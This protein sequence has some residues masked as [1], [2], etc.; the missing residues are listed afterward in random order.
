MKFSVK[1]VVVAGAAVLIAA[2]GVISCGSAPSAFLVRGPGGSGNVPPTLTILQ[3]SSNL[4]R[5]QGDGFII[6]W[7]DSDPDDNALISFDLISTTSNVVVPLVSG[8]PENDNLGPDSFTVSTTLIPVGSYNI[9]GTINDGTNDPV[10]AFAL[11]TAT[12]PQRVIVQIVEAGQGVPTQPPSVAIASPLFDL[13]VTQDDTVFIQIVPSLIGDRPYDRDSITTMWLVLDLD[14]NPL[15]DDPANADPNQI[16]FITQRTIAEGDANPL[17]INFRVDLTAVPPRPGGLP[18][19]IRAT[20]DDGTN[21]RVHHYAV[22]RLHITQLAAGLVDLANVGKSITGSR[23]Y[24][25]NPGANFGSRVTGITDFDADGVDDF[26]MVAQFG[27]PRNVGPVG[28]A[29]LIYGLN[30]Q[31][32]GGTISANSTA[33][34]VPGVIFEAPPVR[35]FLSPG[36]FATPPGAHTHGITDVNILPDYTGDGR[37]ELIFGLPYVIGAFDTTDYD[38]ADDDVEGSADEDVTVE[39]VVRQGQVTVQIGDAGAL[40]T[41]TSYTMQDTTIST[42]VPNTNLGSAQSLNWQND[43]GGTAQW[44]LI[45]FP[46]ILDQIPDGP[47]DIDITTVNATLELR[48]FFPGVS[49]NVHQA[50]TDFTESTTYDS[51]AVNGG[52]PE[53]GVDFRI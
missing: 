39:V 37:P 26:I 20:I 46:N 30:Q 40:T 22:G 1:P 17:N 15:N 50:L 4:T 19:F 24:G 13:S 14:D 11:T 6:S 38:P 31:R 48:T 41:S 5:G 49:A 33:D 51:F 45:K 27:N 18:Y 44:A 8:I 29:Y 10:V 16:I 25:F 3:P 34:T 36:L 7:S 21:P 12:V 9:R 23:F 28:E 42:V 47:F 52:D 32:Y 2:I 43:G 53:A 35:R